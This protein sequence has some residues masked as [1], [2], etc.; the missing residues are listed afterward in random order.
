MKVLTFSIVAGSLA[1]NARCPF[2]VAPM[3]PANGIGTKE[4]EVN[5]RNFRKA[6]QLARDG[7]CSTAMITSKGEPTIFPNQVSRF[8]EE[9]VPFNFPISELQTN[10]LLIADGRVTDEHLTRWYE[11]GLT[12]IAISVVHYERAKNKAIYTHTR[13][14]LDLPALIAKLKKFKFTVR[15]A[16]VLVK[17]YLDSVDEMKKMIEFAT[18]NGVDQLT[19]RPVTRPDKS[20][21]EGIY[22]WTTAHAIDDQLLVDCNQYLSENGSEILEL[23]HG[24][25]VYDVGGQ[26]VCM[27]NC[28]TIQ[29]KSDEMRQIIFYPDGS[30][31]Y[32]WQFSGARLF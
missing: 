12:T 14:Y 29:P 27:T 26:N 30:V 18:A 2:C 3:T 9:L 17:G 28:L 10:G 6:A 15:L 4:P 25:T 13:D 1:C 20:E 31:R 11:L 16:T 8:L 21:N 5:W 32:A 23:A 7:G 24:A 19:F 22:N